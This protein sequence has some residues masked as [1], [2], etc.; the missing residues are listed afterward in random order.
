MRTEFIPGSTYRHYK[1]N[2]YKTL[3]IAKHTETEEP[4]AIYQALYGEHGI[5]ARPLAMFL[6]EVTLPDGS[7]VPRFVLVE[8]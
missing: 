5:W 8:E 6:D 2:L 3:Y 7:V 1:G 4:L